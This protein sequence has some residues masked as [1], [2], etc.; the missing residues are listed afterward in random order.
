MSG[1]ASLKLVR[2]LLAEVA[3]PSSQLAAVAAILAAGGYPDPEEYVTRVAGDRCGAY[4]TFTPG[5]EVALAQLE[6]AFGPARRARALDS[7]G[8]AER[9][10]DIAA[11][12]VD[13][14]VLTAEL[15][16]SEKVVTGVRLTPYAS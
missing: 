11:D 9:Y 16:E 2:A 12:G 6:A 4:L 7:D 3:R 15:D 1:E 14:V 13:H 5:G 10:W 8:P